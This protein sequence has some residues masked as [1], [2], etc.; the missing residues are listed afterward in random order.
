MPVLE[1]I[2]IALQALNS[3]KLRAILTTLGIIIGVAAVVAVVSV[4]QGLSFMITSQ[5]QEAGA[6]FIIVVPNRSP[7]YA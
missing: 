4:V 6:D 3:N 1:N 5:L 2:K 7:G